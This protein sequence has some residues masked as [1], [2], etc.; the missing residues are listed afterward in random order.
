MAGFLGL[1]VRIGWDSSGPSSNY[2]IF[3]QDMIFSDSRVWMTLCLVNEISKRIMNTS[4]T[5]VP[6]GKTIRNES[7][8]TTADPLHVIFLEIRQMT[9]VEH[10]FDHFLTYS[11]VFRGESQ[12]IL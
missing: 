3:S 5:A 11:H 6:R 2:V 12:P 9:Y 7:N 4:Y 10:R 8:V 1:N